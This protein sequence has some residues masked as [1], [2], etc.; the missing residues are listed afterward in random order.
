MSKNSI[1]KN[2]SKENLK[3][4]IR[5]TPPQ[6]WRIKKHW[7]SKYEEFLR[8]SSAVV[9]IRED[10][11]YLEVCNSK[12]SE[13]DL[14]SDCFQLIYMGFLTTP[15]HKNSQNDV[16]LVETWWSWHILGKGTDI[17]SNQKQPDFCEKNHHPNVS[18]AKCS[19]SV[20]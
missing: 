8:T 18:I 9:L 3:S 13:I 20:S 11:E 5:C 6:A 17:Y 10:C 7:V 12:N 15:W 4:N 16:K 1:R 2:I 19:I 14:F